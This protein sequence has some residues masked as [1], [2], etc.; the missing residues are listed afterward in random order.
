MPL[1]NDQQTK[2]KDHLSSHLLHSKCPCCS[3]NRWTI[4]SEL[5]VYPMF[6]TQ[7]KM[8]IEGQVM[9]M[10]IVSCEKCHFSLSFNAMKLGLL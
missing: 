8:I 3:G 2:I 10:A 7:Y 4:E 5:A 9:P 6:D 1:T